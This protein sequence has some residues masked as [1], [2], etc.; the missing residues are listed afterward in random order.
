MKVMVCGARGST[1]VSG[2]KFARYGGSTSCVAVLSGNDDPRL[3][4]DAGTG[5]LGL[6]AAL[7]IR[8]FHGTI[9]LSHL[10]WDHTHGI[11]FFDA[12]MRRG[13]K[14]TLLVPEQGDPLEV[15]ERVMSPPHFPIRPRDF[16][17]RW[18]FASIEEGHHEIEGLRVTA[19]DVPHGGG[20][21]FGY[22]VEDDHGSLAYLP[23]H[24]P[25]D[26]EGP[27]SVEIDS[28][29]REL[30]TGA[31]LLLH[32]SQHTA[33]EIIESPPRGHSTVEYLGRLAHECA[34]SHVV[35]FHHDRKRTDD[36]IDSLIEQYAS[37]I[38]GLRAAAEGV[39]YEVVS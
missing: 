3:V 29:V 37:I 21:T 1:P 14:T 26:G 7:G 25:F 15:L 28:K 33:S 6:S 38:P 12:A 32:D 31:D 35:L 30:C 19:A 27:M 36:D 8:P 23:D 4:L 24:G 34:V 20:R 9:L 39:I 18:E 5:I 22:R 10:H 2:E 11:P 17:G 16:T 13:A